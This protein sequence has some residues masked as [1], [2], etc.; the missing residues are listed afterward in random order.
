MYRFPCGI[1]DTRSDRKLCSQ[2]PQKG[3]TGT[4]G[5]DDVFYFAGTDFTDRVT[6]SRIQHD[7]AS[8]T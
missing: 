7:T 2:C 3:V 4:R 1:R 6:T 8:R 5:V